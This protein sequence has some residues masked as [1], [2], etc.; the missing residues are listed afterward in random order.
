MQLP[1]SGERSNRGAGVGIQGQLAMM[2]DCRL[3]EM[4]TWMVGVPSTSLP[5]N[6]VC[7]SL[8]PATRPARDA[9]AAAGAAVS[10]NTKYP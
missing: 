4:A 2:P 8:S 9:T 1:E 6:R 3:D 5:K 10:S 7:A